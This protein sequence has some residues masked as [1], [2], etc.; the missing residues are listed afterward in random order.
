MRSY[1]LYLLDE[2][3]VNRYYGQEIKLFNLFCE[4]FQADHTLKPLLTKQ[5]EYITKPL[6]TKELLK[7]LSKEDHYLS[8]EQVNVSTYRMEHSPS[9]SWVDVKLRDHH[10]LLMAF[11]KMEIETRLFER[12]K[13]LNTYFFAVNVGQR[14]FGWLGPIKKVQAFQNSH[15]I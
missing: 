7:I 14:R 15:S 11:G 10:L 12:L 2:A 9:G 13:E 8:S 4:R 5:V 3:I 1:Q 6:P